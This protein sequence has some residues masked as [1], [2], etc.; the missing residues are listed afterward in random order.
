M[1]ELARRGRGG[2]EKWYFTIST[3]VKSFL[4]HCRSLIVT[5]AV[6][7]AATFTALL[8]SYTSIFIILL[9]FLSIAP[10]P[11]LWILIS[12][13]TIPKSSISAAFP[14]FA[15]SVASEC[16]KYCALFYLHNFFCPCVPVFSPSCHVYLYLESYPIPVP[17]IL[18][19]IHWMSVFFCQTNVWEWVRES[20]CFIWKICRTFPLTAPLF[21]WNCCPRSNYAQIFF[22]CVLVLRASCSS[23]PHTCIALDLS[24][25]V[26]ITFCPHP[27]VCLM[28]LMPPLRN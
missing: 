21:D 11:S 15:I 24:F 20:F 4:Y 8:P 14:F 10:S 7:A 19:R 23:P 12:L 28:H 16:P 18:I 17:T 22:V 2:P 27:F 5:A 25:F 13:F 3:W 9:L 1:L 6:A 26:R